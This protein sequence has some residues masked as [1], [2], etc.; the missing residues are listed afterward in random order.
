MGIRANRFADSQESFDSR[1][2][3]QG[4]RTEPPFCESRFEGLKIANRRFGANRANRSHDTKKRG[5]SA[6]RRVI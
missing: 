2:S 4:S 3:F 6:N 1:K 5:F